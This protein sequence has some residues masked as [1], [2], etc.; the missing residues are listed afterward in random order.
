MRPRPP[1]RQDLSNAASHV[2][3]RSLV[4]EIAWGGGGRYTSPVNGVRLRSPV[5]RGLTVMP[6]DD[7][8]YP[9][10]RSPP[11]KKTVDQCDFLQ[12]LMTFYECVLLQVAGVTRKAIFGVFEVQNSI[13]FF[14]IPKYRRNLAFGT[15]H[16]QYVCI[17]THK[18]V[19]PAVRRRLGA[20]RVAA[21]TGFCPCGSHQKVGAAQQVSVWRPGQ[22]NAGHCGTSRRR[23]KRRRTPA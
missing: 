20:R 9:V 21:R 16:W 10:C 18:V 12:L 23:L 7:P 2:S 3:L 4:W 8:K 19:R 22:W 1:S 5:S 15:G 11:Q 14:R 13:I 17:P 6:P